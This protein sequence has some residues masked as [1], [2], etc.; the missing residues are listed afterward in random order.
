MHQDFLF[1]FAKS[2]SGVTTIEDVTKNVYLGSKGGARGVPGGPPQN[3]AWPPSAPPKLGL[4][5]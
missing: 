4:F 2:K 1:L 3:F 5:L